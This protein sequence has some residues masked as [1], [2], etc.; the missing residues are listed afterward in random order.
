[1]NSKSGETKL[2]SSKAQ[3]RVKGQLRNASSLQ[4]AGGRDIT[5]GF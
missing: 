2:E 1:M 3:L 5:E 4:K